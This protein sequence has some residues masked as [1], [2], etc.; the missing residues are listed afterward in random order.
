ME[1]LKRAS[2][3]GWYKNN[4]FEILTWAGTPLSVIWN[5]E[6]WRFLPGDSVVLEDCDGNVQKF[7]K[8]LF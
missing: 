5:Q 8:G 7:V 4:E 3:T 1:E 2:Y 6:K